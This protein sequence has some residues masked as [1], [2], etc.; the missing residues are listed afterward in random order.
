M[1]LRS[2]PHTDPE[3]G[4]SALRTLGVYFAHLAVLS[5]FAVAQPLFDLLGESPDFFAVRGSSRWDIML[6]ALAIVL[7][8]PAAL[9]LVEAVACLVYRPFQRVVHLLFVAG[10]AGVVMIQALERSVDIASTTCW[11]VLL[12][13]WARSSPSSTGA[14]PRRAPC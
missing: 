12:C 14:S 7:V 6:F 11:S 3:P 10:L 4:E 9:I 1:L 8:P 13:F 5:A 2:A